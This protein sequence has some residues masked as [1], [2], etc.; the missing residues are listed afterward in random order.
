MCSD[1]HILVT[2]KKCAEVGMATVIKE[3][4]KRGAPLPEALAKVLPPPLYFEVE[5]LAARGV[6]VEELRVRLARRAFVT[7]GGKNMPLEYVCE[8]DVMDAIVESICDGS[9]YAHADTIKNGYLTLDDGIR[10]GIVGRAAV[11]GGRVIG[12]YDVSALCIRIPRAIC[13]LGGRIVGLIR[14]GEICGGVLVYSPPGEGKTTL[15]RAL[16]AALSSGECAKRV[17]VVD[18][19]GELGAFLDDRSLSV[20]ILTGYPKHVGIEIAARSMNA[21][22]IVCD[23]IGNEAEIGAMIAAQNCGVPLIASAHA[24]SIRGLLRRTGLAAMHRAAIFGAYVGI[25]RVEGERDYR[26]RVVTW[27]EANELIKNSRSDDSGVVWDS[28]IVHTQ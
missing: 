18:E 19:R 3:R 8:K 9:V 14:S 4:R 6:C 7:F 5:T 27:E 23:E 26:Y 21:E 10:I 28:R 22:L 25:R 13:G 1:E 20:D 2:D 12:V 16:T 24:D 17:A 11:E 15:L